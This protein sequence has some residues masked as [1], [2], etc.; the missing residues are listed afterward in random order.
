MKHECDFRVSI[1][2]GDLYYANC[3]R[4]DMLNCSCFIKKA[5]VKGMIHEM[6]IVLSIKH[7]HM[8]Y[9]MVTYVPQKHIMVTYV[10]QEHNMVPYMP[11]EHNMVTYVPQEHNLEPRLM[12]HA[13]AYIHC[14]LMECVAC[15]IYS[16]FARRISMQKSL[17]GKELMY[18]SIGWLHDLNVIVF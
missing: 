1:K 6:Y 15:F 18:I 14:D 12:V 10:L 8:T 9:S 5:S 11:Q 2:F 16:S 3:L 4:N 13:Y 7:K 17:N